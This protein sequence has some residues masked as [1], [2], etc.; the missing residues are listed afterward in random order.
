MFD[1]A[2]CQVVRRSSTIL[3]GALLMNVFVAEACL[4]WMRRLSPGGRS[5]FRR[6]ESSTSLSTASP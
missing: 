5:L 6:R 2:R 4:L 1:F 3:A